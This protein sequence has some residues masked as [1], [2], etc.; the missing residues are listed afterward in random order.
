MRLEMIP[1]HGQGAV[2]EA[3]RAVMVTSVVILTCSI[4]RSERSGMI[5]IGSHRIWKTSCRRVGLVLQ[6]TTSGTAAANLRKSQKASIVTDI[7][8]KCLKRKYLIS[9]RSRK[10]KRS[11]LLGSL[12]VGD[13][14]RRQV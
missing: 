6:Y 14:P 3:A 5:V 7:V 2:G 1:Q 8:T 12:C 13:F 4:T 9:R 11:A 10:A